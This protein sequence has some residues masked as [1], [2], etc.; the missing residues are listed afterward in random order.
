MQPATTDNSM[1]LSAIRPGQRVRVTRVEGGQGLRGRLCAMGLTP[2]LT[3]QVAC[4]G[5]GPVVLEV[6]GSRV[7]IGR[8][9]AEK[10]RVRAV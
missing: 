6:L 1:P 8:G 3:V 2:G 5:G 7:M 9:M 10:I 4:D